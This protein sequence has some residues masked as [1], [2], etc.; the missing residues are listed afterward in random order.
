MFTI[1]SRTVRLRRSGILR[2]TMQY[3]KSYGEVIR[4][5]GIKIAM[6]KISETTV[7]SASKDGIF[8]PPSAQKKKK[9]YMLRMLYKTRMSS[10]VTKPPK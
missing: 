4:H 1:E 5:H 3:I 2:A 9:I 10:N 6:D 7:T 8:A